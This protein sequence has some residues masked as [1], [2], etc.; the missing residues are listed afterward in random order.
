MAQGIT[1]GGPAATAAAG[2]VADS[3]AAKARASLQT[4]SPSELFRN[5]GLNVSEGLALG[6]QGGAHRAVA[7]T[8]SLAKGVAVAGGGVHIPLAGGAANSNGGGGAGGGAVTI[9]V[10][11]VPKPGASAAEQG[12]DAGEAAEKALRAYMRKRAAGG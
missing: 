6:I 9:I 7:A 12:Q 1:A 3:V 4:H 5:I 8:G 2:A 10:Q 11:I